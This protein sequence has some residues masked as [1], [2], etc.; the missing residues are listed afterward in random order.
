MI[1]FSLWLLF[2]A[3]PYLVDVAYCEDLSPSHFA[4][5]VL[6]DGEEVDPSEANDCTSLP[7]NPLGYIGSR[8][9]LWRADLC[10]HFCRARASVS[11]QHLL[12]ASLT[13]RPPPHPLAPLIAL[14]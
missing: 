1:Q 6:G 5:A 8:C 7:D 4:Q 3:L 14:I 11:P 12:L 10:R 13:F 9:V 2:V